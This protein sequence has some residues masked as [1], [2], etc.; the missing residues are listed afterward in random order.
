M[1]LDKNK[2]QESK[3]RPIYNVQI[4]AYGN[5]KSKKICEH[6]QRKFFIIFEL[7]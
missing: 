5:Q 1:F 6:N 4:S 7:S 2:C 3:P